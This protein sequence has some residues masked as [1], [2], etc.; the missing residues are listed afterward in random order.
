MSI[1]QKINFL[2]LILG[3]AFFLYGMTVMSNGLK[4][5]SGSSLELSLQINLK[6]LPL[7]RVLQLLFSHHLP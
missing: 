6:V 7:V 3:L 4:K 1:L 2:H 5:M